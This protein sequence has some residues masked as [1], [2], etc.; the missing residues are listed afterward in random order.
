MMEEWDD[1]WTIPTPQY[2]NIP[3]FQCSKSSALNYRLHPRI[4]TRREKVS[5]S[6]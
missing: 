4:K 1:R 2:P 5:W 6:L 3:V